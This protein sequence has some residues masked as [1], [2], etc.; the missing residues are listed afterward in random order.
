MVAV[1]SQ[2]RIRSID[3]DFDRGRGGL[4]NPRFPEVSHALNAFQLA[5]P[6]L[7]PYFIDAIKEAA[8]DIAD[9]RLRADARAFCAQ[10][11]NHARQ[12]ARYNRVLRRRYPHVE[13]F[14]RSI[15]RS[16]VRSR[17]RDSLA[18]RL[19]FTAACEAIT[20]ELARF[21][22]G[23]ADEWFRDADGHFAALMLWHAVE[24]IEHKAVAFDVLRAAGV[25]HRS[26]APALL[27]A[28]RQMLFDLDPIATYLLAV[29]G[30]GGTAS[31]LRRLAFRLQFSAAVGPRLLKYAAPGYNPSRDPDPPFAQ[32]WM[33]AHARGMPLDVVDSANA[34][35]FTTPR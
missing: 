28:V 30:I 24:E 17:R 25:P 5:L 22:F 6:Y 8:R 33:T 19:S 18:W 35:A 10:E 7:E 16:L 13:I 29:D 1:S 32:E 9:P 15:Q 27:S 21:L 11:A 14:E 31:Q 2:I 12:H 26:R 23:H 4:W 20:G 34:A 3:F